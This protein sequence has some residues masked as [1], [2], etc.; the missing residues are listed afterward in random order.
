MTHLLLKIKFS[1][2]LDIPAALH[3]SRLKID[4]QMPTL[5]ISAYSFEQKLHYHLKIETYKFMNPNYY[6]YYFGE[7]NAL[8]LEIL[9][10]PTPYFWKNIHSDIFYNP[11]NQYTWWDMYY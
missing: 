2:K 4:I 11:P 3:V 6:T 8:V 10:S 9:K 7:L 1:R 5:E